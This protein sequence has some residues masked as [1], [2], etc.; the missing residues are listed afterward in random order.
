MVSPDDTGARYLGGTIADRIRRP[1]RYL[2]EV[3]RAFDADGRVA[4][5]IGIVADVT[6]A[7]RAEGAH[8]SEARFQNMADTAPMM[9][10]AWSR[11][12]AIFSIG[13]A[14]IYGSHAETGTGYGWT[15]GIHPD[16][17]DAA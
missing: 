9:I 1:N 17:L 7:R 13:R 11:Q 8:E 16:D 4:R 2:H 6:A 14:G 10:C 3:T 15:E 12:A 5:Y